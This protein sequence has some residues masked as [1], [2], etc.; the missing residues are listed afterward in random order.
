MTDPVIIDRYTAARVYFGGVIGLIFLESLIPFSIYT[1]Q[2]YNKYRL[3]DRNVLH[4]SITVWLHKLHSFQLPLPYL[5]WHVADAAR[6]TAFLTLN[7][8]FSV[9]SNEFTADYT[10]YG[11]L[12]IANAGL[13]LLMAS[14][15]NLFAS[16]LRIPSPFLLQYHRWIGLATVAHATA[17]VSFNIQHYIETKQVTTS[18]GNHRIQLGLTAWISLALLFLTALPIVRRRFF[19]VFYYTHALFFVFVVGALI[20]ASHGP[21]FMLPGLLLWGIDRVIRFAYNFRTIQVQSVEAFDG[22]VTKFKVKGLRTRTPGQVVW[23]QIPR[24]SF[25]NWH[26]FTVASAPNDPEKTATIAVRGLGGFTKAV[27]YADCNGDVNSHGCDSLDSNSMMSHP[28]KMRLD[29]PYGVG[30]VSWG[31]LPVTVLVAGGI[32]ITPGISIASHIIRQTGI[33]VG[34]R[35]A[36]HVHLLWVV[37]DAQHIQWFADELADLA[38]ACAKPNSTTTLE[39][40]IFVTGGRHRE[41]EMSH[42]SHEMQVM[43][44]PQPWSIHSG[45]PDLKQWFRQ[46]KS[47]HLGMDAAV[48][49]CG[50]RQLIEQGREAACGV[51]D[52]EGLFF[53]QEEVFE[54]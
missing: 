38:N 13:S 10:L 47:N 31:L 11:W 7:L 25:V 48:N 39:I 35:F 45:R 6:F 19:E 5:D 17:H 12:A 22:N 16:L 8:I 9:Q 24:V 34:S 4:W 29:G 30:S 27:Q 33:D 42:P 20:H 23:L 26:P 37:R 32:G 53:V 18:F 14:R 51:S 36:S 41:V 2:R 52:R 43:S 40:A 46:L 3:Q 50:P 54:L 1:F 44:S 15:N 49:L 21:E 28:L